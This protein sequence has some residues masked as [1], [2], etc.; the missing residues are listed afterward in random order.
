MDAAAKQSV[1]AGQIVRK[2]RDYVS[3]GEFET[4]PT[5]LQ[6]VVS[7]AVSVA[8][9]GIDGPVPRIVQ[10]I[11]DDL[12]NVLIDGLQIRQVVLN[13]IRNAIDALGDKDNPLI[14]IRAWQEDDAV[15]IEVRDNGPGLDLE[16]GK[17]PFEPF[18]STKSHGMGLGLSICQAIVEA[19]GGEIWTVHENDAGAIFRISLA[20]TGG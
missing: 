13:L 7:N 19:H 8:K 9:V 2:L 10:R 18:L 17:S 11:P 20:A 3:R 6:D 12:P 15:L 5:S 16:E 4:R 1:R 14:E